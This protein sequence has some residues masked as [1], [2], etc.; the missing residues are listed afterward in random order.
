MAA[1]KGEQHHSSRHPGPDRYKGKK[2]VVVGSNNSARDICAALFE[3]GIDVTMVQRSSTH[4]V[5][6]ASLMEIGLGDLY[7][8]RAVHGGMTTAKAD[9]I[10][11]SVP[12]AILAS[13]ANR[14]GIGPGPFARSCPLATQSPGD[15]QGGGSETRMAQG[16][17]RSIGVGAAAVTEGAV[18]SPSV[19]GRPSG[20]PLDCVGR[21]PRSRPTGG[22]RLVMDLLQSV[23]RRRDSLEAGL[24]LQ[25]QELRIMA[26]LVQVAAVEP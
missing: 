12:Y 3:S 19:D 26:R 23:D 16:A 8:E 20:R 22:S 5:R 15:R 24:Q 14:T 7:S 9:L 18:A 6:S 11:A 25:R 17:R 2:V 4:I 21:D 13:V 10:F 1:F